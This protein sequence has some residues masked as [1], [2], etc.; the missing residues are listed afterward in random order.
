MC[1]EILV[2][3]SHRFCLPAPT[4]CPSYLTWILILFKRLFQFKRNQQITS[5][6]E[7]KIMLF[8]AYV[9]QITDNVTYRYVIV[10]ASRA[11]ADEWWRAVST[12]TVT[13]FTSS[14]QRISAQFYT[15]NVNLANAADSL[16]TTGVATQFIGKV[17][18]TLLNDLGGRGLN[19]IPPPDHF[20][21]HI[22]GNSFFIRSKVYPYEYWYYPTS[23]NTTQA[24]YVSRTERTRFT[25]S[26]TDSGTTG[27]VIINSD[28]IAITL[29]SANLSINVNA[30]TGQVI[31]SATPQSGLTF[32]DLLGYFTVGSS[33][34]LNDENLK[35]LL[36]TE[37][38]E[39]WE[40]A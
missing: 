36:Y 32:S 24:V 31:L 25:V 37:H 33:L 38:G 10:F 18:F 30:T 21:D 13:S 11:V 40:L 39:E 2:S 26:R 7:R 14:V 23:D 22:S 20:A 15:H 19:I 6:I 34:S 28:E 9:K 35:E 16:T 1:D 3:S 12:S 4:L 29:A 27:T 5:P 8:Y 17:F